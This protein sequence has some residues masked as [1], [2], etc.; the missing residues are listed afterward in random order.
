MR[1]ATQK[2]LAAPPVS[3]RWRWLLTAD[4]ARGQNNSTVYLQVSPANVAVEGLSYRALGL[5]GSKTAA[6]STLHSNAAPEGNAIPGI[7]EPGFYPADVSNPMQV[8][9]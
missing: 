5:I 2:H 9:A 8:P 6:P 3:P 7:A 4:F 1:L